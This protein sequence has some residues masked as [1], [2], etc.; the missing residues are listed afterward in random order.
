MMMK[1]TMTTRTTTV[2]MMMVL[3]A[4]ITTT[5]IGT[6]AYAQWQ[7]FEEPNENI[8]AYVNKAIDEAQNRTPDRIVV[9]YDSA[10]LIVYWTTFINA[11]APDGRV[12]EIEETT[13]FRMPHNFTA[14]NGYTYRDGTIYKP[15]GTELFAE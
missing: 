12:F 9:Y 13:E 15:D 14:E 4:T 5:T 1:T 2:M 11:T 8:L 7:A 10:F 6:A 3:L